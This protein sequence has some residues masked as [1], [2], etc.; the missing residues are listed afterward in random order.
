MKKLIV[1]LSSQQFLF[2]SLLLLVKKVVL[3]LAKSET[4]GWNYNDTKNGG[5]EKTQLRRTSYRTW[6]GSWFRVVPILMGQKDEDVM[7]DWN[8]VAR[9]VTVPSF[10]MDEAEISNIQYREY[11]YCVLAR[12]FGESFPQVVQR[13]TTRYLSLER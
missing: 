5:F 10:Y 9:R 7:R 1:Y 4:T 13:A 2:R 12:V 11:N 3:R 6:I 8:N